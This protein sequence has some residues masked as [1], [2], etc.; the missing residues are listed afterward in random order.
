[1]TERDKLNAIYR[2]ILAAARQKGLARYSDLIALQGLVPG[3]P[4]KVTLRIRLHK[5]LKIC[6]RRD[7][8]A[9]SAIVVGEYDAL[10]SEKGLAGFVEGAENAGYAVQN[11][12]E[13]EAEQKEALYLWAP[14]APDSLDL[15]DRKIQK[16]SQPIRSANAGDAVRMQG[17]RPKTKTAPWPAGWPPLWLKGILKTILIP[18]IPMVTAGLIVAYR[19]EIWHFFK[20]L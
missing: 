10:L 1:M 3:Q 16:F 5:L 8:P 7:W 15:G 12:R 18:V 11:P 19:H 4:P 20:Q 9:M 2:A 17:E 6:R 14:S 13:F